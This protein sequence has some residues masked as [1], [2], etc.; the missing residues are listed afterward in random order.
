MNTIERLYHLTKTTEAVVP[1]SVNF[2]TEL[3]EELNDPL[4]R[5]DQIIT[6]YHAR[7]GT[8]NCHLLK[9]NILARDFDLYEKIPPDMYDKMQPGDYVVEFVVTDNSFSRDT[10]Y[11][12]LKNIV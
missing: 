1:V 10:Y 12:L 4:N 8:F 3:L 11:E 5:L 7:Q 2:L 6:A 9:F